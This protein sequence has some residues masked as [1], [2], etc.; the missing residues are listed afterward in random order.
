MQAGLRHQRPVPGLHRYKRKK[1]CWL[2]SSIGEPR[3]K[4]GMVSGG[5]KLAT[6]SPMSVIALE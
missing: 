4:P 6:F 1:E 5:K 2:K 3:Y